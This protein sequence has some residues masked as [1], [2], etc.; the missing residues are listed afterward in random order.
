MLEVSDSFWLVVGP[1]NLYFH[2]FLDDTGPRNNFKNYS[3]GSW[4]AGSVG[5]FKDQSL[6][7]QDLHKRQNSRT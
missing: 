7:P 2:E 6:D 1:E 5:K 4:G 3:F